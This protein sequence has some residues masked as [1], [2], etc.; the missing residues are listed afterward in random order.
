V[1]LDKHNPQ[2]LHESYTFGFSYSQQNVEAEFSNLAVSE[3]GSERESLKLIVVKSSLELMERR[4]LK[5]TQS[6][7]PLP[8]EK[9]LAK[10]SILMTAVQRFLT[11]SLRYTDACPDSYEPQGFK[12]YT[13]PDMMLEDGVEHIPCGPWEAGFHQ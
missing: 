11:M 3:K 7:M 12:N 9:C 13:G 8:G 5:I 6:L 2:L 4:I 10:G 1:Y